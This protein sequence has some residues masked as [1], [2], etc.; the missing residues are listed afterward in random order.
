MTKMTKLDK[1]R[2]VPNPFHPKGATYP[3]YY[4]NRD[5]VLRYFKEDVVNSSKSKITKPDHILI[6][7]DWGIGKTSTL[8]KFKDILHNELEKRG[9]VSFSSLIA[10]K[11]SFCKDNKTF[12]LALLKNITNDYSLSTPTSQKLKNI[13]KE[14][15]KLFNK[16]EI[17]KLSVKGPELERKKDEQVS[18]DLV[19][20]LTKFWNVLKS[21]KIEIAVIMLDDIQYLLTEGWKEGLY[22]LRTDIQTLSAK[23]CNYMF[24]CSGNLD[25]FPEMYDLAEPFIRLF[26]RFKLKQF[27][28]EGTK[29]IIEK[30]MRIEKVQIQI[31]EE[32]I[33]K[34]YEITEGHPY[35]IT[36]IMHDVIKEIKEGRV[37]I[38]EFKDIYP[39][40]TEHLASMR[41]QDDYNKA[42]PTEREVLFKIAKTNKKEVSPSDIKVKSVNK[43]LERLTEKNLLIKISRG[44]YKLYHSLFR[45]Y[46]LSTKNIWGDCY[47]N[48]N[49]SIIRFKRN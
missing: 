10:I 6:L 14:E 44:S 48:E 39:K 4:A 24:V 11:P 2:V 13:I 34:I 8:Y 21:N 49:H 45:E 33:K 15:A 9:I 3:K 29:E 7:G 5:D 37:D 43:I 41:F 46:L 12:N 20:N 35:F 26:E 40:I 30:P 18:I 19:S 16:W 38:R 1:I 42:T 27:D 22:D 47:G 36:A 32:V 28:F 23:G 25:L 31:G 17:S